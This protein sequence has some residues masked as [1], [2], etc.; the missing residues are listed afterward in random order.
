MRC[1][2]ARALRR[3]SGSTSDLAT[4]RSSTSNA[5]S[6]RAQILRRP[7]SPL[8]LQ[9]GL[10][11][12]VLDSLAET[13]DRDRQEVELQLARGLSLLTAKGFSSTEAVQ[14]YARARNLCEKRGDSDHLFVALWNL[15]MTTA[16]RDIDA[17]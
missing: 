14:S 9:S 4:R 13:A 3:R 16:V 12:G 10:G 1:S 6:T 17:A 15:W 5:R 7:G 2:T 8:W 11:L